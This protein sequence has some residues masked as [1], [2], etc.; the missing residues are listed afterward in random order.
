MKGEKKMITRTDIEKLAELRREK[1]RIEK[2][3]K[4]MTAELLARATENG[5]MWKGLS[6]RIDTGI[7]T[8]P[9]REL[10]NQLPN[11]EQY[12]KTTEYKK[13]VIKA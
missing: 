4:A 10:I 5:H 3:E 12:Y 6:Y 2:E 1:A 13:I 9:N 7:N 11:H 8:S